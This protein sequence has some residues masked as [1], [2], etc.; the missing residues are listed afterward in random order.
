MAKQCGPFILERTIDD[1]IFYKMDGKGYVRLKPVFPDI[2]T[3]PRFRGTMKY[4][5]WMARASRIGAALYASL[6]AGFKQ[7]PMYRAFVGE[8]MYL[9]KAGKTDQE[10]LQE[11]KVQCED[12]MSRGVRIVSVIY[13]ALAERFKQESLF[14]GWVEEAVTLLKK[15]KT[16]EEVGRGIRERYVVGCDEKKAFKRAVH[17]VTDRKISF[18]PRLPAVAYRSIAV[19]LDGGLCGM[20]CLKRHTIRKR[21]RAPF[22]G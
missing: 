18:V 5:R 22:D 9:L 7:F 10:A 20:G 8:A 15:G 13:T 11:L 17:R 2:R 14:W 19:V 3:S 21:A 12:F 6:P 16:E 1:V 4:A